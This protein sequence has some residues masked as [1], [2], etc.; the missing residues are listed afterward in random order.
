MELFRAEER[1]GTAQLMLD[2]ALTIFRN[3]G[4]RSP[5]NSN[6]GSEIEPILVASVVLT[7]HVG[8]KHKSASDVGRMLNIPRV[9]ARRKLQELI[10]RVILERH[11]T[12]KLR[13][14]HRVS[15]RMEHA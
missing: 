8:G 11:R 14:D 9:T 3:G 15:S 13:R 6:L 4:M 10:G 1:A 5:P 7:G 2:L 12:A